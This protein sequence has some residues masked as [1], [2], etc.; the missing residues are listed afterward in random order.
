MAA[1]LAPPCRGEDCFA[2]RGSQSHT[3]RGE[4][5]P[6][7]KPLATQLGMIRRATSEDFPGTEFSTVVVSST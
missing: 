6:F 2:M 5:I 3:R 7:Y 1:D 4:M